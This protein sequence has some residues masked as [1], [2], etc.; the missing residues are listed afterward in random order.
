[1]ENV[2]NVH[3]LKATLTFNVCKQ[4]LRPD[5][6]GHAMSHLHAISCPF[7]KLFECKNSCTKLIESLL[8][9]PSHIVLAKQI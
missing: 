8:L 9:S 2:L 4:C 3:K 7:P 6:R 5:V 1:M